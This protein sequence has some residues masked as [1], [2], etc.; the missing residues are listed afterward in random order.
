VYQVQEIKTLEK[1]GLRKISQVSLRFSCQSIVT[2]SLGEKVKVLISLRA[3]DFPAGTDA[4]IYDLLDPSK[5]LDFIV[6]SFGDMY[7]PVRMEVVHIK[8]VVN[9]N[10]GIF[11]E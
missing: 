5:Y 2:F 1:G 6:V 10:Q 4:V 11:F 7:I 9:H 8:K 3:P